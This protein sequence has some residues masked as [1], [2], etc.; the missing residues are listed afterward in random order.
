MQQ[1]MMLKLM[2]GVKPYPVHEDYCI[3][4]IRLLE[5]GKEDPKEIEAWVNVCRLDDGGIK[6][7]YEK[8]ITK[9]PC[10]VPATDVFFAC[11]KATDRPVA[12]LTAHLDDRGDGW[13][14]MV[15]SLPEVRGKKLGH[16]MLASGLERLAKAGVSRVWLTTDD[17]RRPAIKNYLAAGF[18]PVI[19]EDNSSDAIPMDERWNVLLDEMGWED[20]TYLTEDGEIWK[21]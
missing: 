7:I 5:N 10:L 8:S 21:K 17:F 15:G 19:C 14:H 4:N 6:E 13:I 16:A 1:L 3:R 11:E 12:T 20:R 2:G 9:T 18:C